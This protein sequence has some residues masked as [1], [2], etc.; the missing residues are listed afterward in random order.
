[1]IRNTEELAKD[2]S[3]A[4]KHV[5]N[6]LDGDKFV[7]LELAVQAASIAEAER[8]IGLLQSRIKIACHAAKEAY[9][10]GHLQKIYSEK[11]TN[12]SRLSSQFAE[13]TKQPEES[14]A[15]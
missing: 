7:D 8:L 3:I 12:Y 13:F 2:S 4:I 5:I 15:S 9:G 6:N 11:E 14:A 10:S 1:M